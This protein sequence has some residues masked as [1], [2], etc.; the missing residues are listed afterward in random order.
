MYLNISLEI[1]ANHYGIFWFGACEF[2]SLQENVLMW[3][4]IWFLCN[5]TKKK[6][7]LRHS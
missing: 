5:K 1:I 7:G 4:L 6:P 3:F 2:T